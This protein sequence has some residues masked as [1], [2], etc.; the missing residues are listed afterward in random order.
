MDS[1]REHEE[2]NHLKGTLVRSLEFILYR[3]EVSYSF[4]LVSGVQRR[5]S[6]LFVPAS[7]LFQTHFPHRLF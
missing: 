2:R 1:L 5:D 3:S 4:V 7:V 6:A